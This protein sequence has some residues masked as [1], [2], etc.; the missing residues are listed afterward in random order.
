MAYINSCIVVK[1]TAVPRLT[2][3]R[4]D[5]SCKY[6]IQNNCIDLQAEY[7]NMQDVYVSD[8]HIGFSSLHSSAILSGWITQTALTEFL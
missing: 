4:A 8:L 1:G 2:I 5:I 7:W 6:K 3:E